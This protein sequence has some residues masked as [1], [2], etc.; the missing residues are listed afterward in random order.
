MNNFSLLLPADFIYLHLAREFAKEVCLFLPGYT[1]VPGFLND[2]ELAVSEACTNAM[3][4]GKKNKPNSQIRLNLKIFPGKFVI[5]V[6]DQGK[7]FDLEKVPIPNMEIPQENGYGIF[8]IKLKMNSVEYQRGKNWNTITM[9]KHYSFI[10]MTLPSS[11]TSDSPL[12][13][14]QV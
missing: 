11:N 13:S 3:I 1:C 2:V 4:H 12:K 7:G 8:L 14:S 9:K 10:D 5:R 6:M